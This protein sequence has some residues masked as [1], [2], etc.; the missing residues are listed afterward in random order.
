[1]AGRIRYRLGV[2]LSATRPG[3][4]A[5]S[6]RPGRTWKNPGGARGLAG[7]RGRG[8]VLDDAADR[9]H[10][11]PTRPHPDRAGPGPFPE[12]AV[13]CRPDL[14]PAWRA[15]P[16]DLPAADRRTDGRKSFAWTDYRDLIVAA[17]RQLGG[18]IVL[19]WD[20][21]NTHLAAGMK[22]FVA[23]H[24]WLTVIQLPAH[25]PELNLIEGIWALIRQDLANTAFADPEH[26]IGAVRRSLREIQYRP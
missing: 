16:A 25:A 10:L 17:H 26:L 13:R 6:G 15:V 2:R 1:M 5:G 4:P 22:Q 23:D 8:R 3:S 12:A 11:V 14:L 24:D 21:L 7:L 20:N 19:V 18:P 9:T